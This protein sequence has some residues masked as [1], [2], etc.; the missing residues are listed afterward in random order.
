MYHGAL[1]EQFVGQE[2]L[3]AGMDKLFYWSREAK[4]SS[5][6]VD[7]LIVKNNKIYPVEIKSIRRVYRIAGG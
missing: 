2:F 6:E 3:S 4:S 7:Y 5:A 1:S